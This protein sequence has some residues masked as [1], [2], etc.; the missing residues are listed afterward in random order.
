MCVSETGIP[1]ANGKVNGCI[2]GGC[3]VLSFPLDFLMIDIDQVIADLG[4]KLV[5]L[6]KSFGQDYKLAEYLPTWI[7]ND[8]WESEDLYSDI[9]VIPDAKE[10]LHY[11]ESIGL[12]FPLVTA[13]PHKL[14]KLTI[15]WLVKNDIPFKTVFFEPYPFWRLKY[16]VSHFLVDDRPY[17]LPPDYQ[18]PE[19]IKVKYPYNKNGD[20][21][22]E[23]F[24]LLE[25][26]GLVRMLLEETDLY[27][28]KYSSKVKK[29]L[30][31][32]NSVVS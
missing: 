27:T 22:L 3:G 9:D 1:E 26:N 21:V 12:L 6:S 20:C 7:P 14:Q 8:M 10:F 30:E 23:I 28:G 31:E 15:S 25:L 19:I 16:K 5:D 2:D 24:S 18:G 4:T 13:R 11:W 32:K 29:W 17:K